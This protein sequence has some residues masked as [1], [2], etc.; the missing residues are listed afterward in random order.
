[1]SGWS[2]FLNLGKEAGDV[3]FG[4]YAQ[5]T[6][7]GFETNDAGFQTSAD[8]IPYSGFVNRRW[9]KPGKVFRFYFF[10]NNL[11]YSENFDRVRNGLR[12]NLN[13]QGTFLNYWNADA[14][15]TRNWRSLSDDLTRGGPLA[16]LPAFWNVSAGVGTDTRR[17]FSTY[18]GL[19]Y[20]RN[21]ID[22]WGASWYANRLQT[23]DRHDDLGSAVVRASDSKLQYVQSQTDASAT[24][25]YGRQYCHVRGRPTQP[26]PDHSAQRDLPAEPVAAIVRAAVHG[27]RRFSRSQGAR[28]RAIARL[29]RVRAVRWFDAWMLQREGPGDRVRSHDWTS[30]TTSAMRMAPARA[31]RP[32][33]QS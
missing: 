27:N 23:D 10:G 6:S 13:T 4:L 18:N 24:A 21:E 32:Y 22:G 5:T 16:D 1:M 25:T 19:S 14:H 8:D 20:S 17:R 7:P 31:Q 26:R 11:T 12:Y 29:S 2:G 15:F 9:S 33:R 28:A 3:Q 30:R